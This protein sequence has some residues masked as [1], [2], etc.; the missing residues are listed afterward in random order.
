M[1]Y[2]GSTGNCDPGVYKSRYAPYMASFVSEFWRAIIV[3]E[4]KTVEVQHKKNEWVIRNAR[5][6]TR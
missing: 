5:V 3:L 1:R 6:G 2:S 4:W